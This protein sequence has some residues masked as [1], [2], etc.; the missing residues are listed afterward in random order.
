MDDV[1]SEVFQTLEKEN[2][3]GFFLPMNYSVKS[4]ELINSALH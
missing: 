1:K 3:M 2:E 4:E